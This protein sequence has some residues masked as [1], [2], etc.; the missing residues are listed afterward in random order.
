MKL[1][2]ATSEDAAALAALARAAF[3][4]AFGHLYRPEDLAAFLGEWRTPERFAAAI[5]DPAARVML[6]EEHGAL[7]AYCST[8]HGKGFEEGP[9]PRPARPAYLAQLYCAQAAT[10]RGLGALLI[11]DA[12]AEA[13][14]RGCDAMQLSV[15][16]G[17]HGA[18]RFYR[19]YG[20]AKVADIHFRVGEQLDEEYLFEKPLAG[21]HT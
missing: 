5:A 10:G 1:R 14:R 18:Q 15:Y 12:I 6:V 11:E 21:E 3:A 9:E 16:S 20:F 13:S 19:R 8:I 4:D 7:I 2:P 17:N